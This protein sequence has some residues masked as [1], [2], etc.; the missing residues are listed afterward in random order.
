[1]ALSVTEN[2]RM[3]AGGRAWRMVSVTH[4]GSVLSVS[5]GSLDLTYIQ[6]IVG[7]HCYVSMQAN[8]SIPLA[9]QTCSINASNNGIVWAEADANAVSY[10]TVVGW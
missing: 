8:T 7:Y 6:A 2:F 9:L 5:A 10:I 3:T 1:M 4:D